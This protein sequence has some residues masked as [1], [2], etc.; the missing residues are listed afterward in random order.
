M[1]PMCAVLDESTSAMSEMNEEHMYTTMK[2]LGITYLSI[3]HRSTLQKVNSEWN[4]AMGVLHIRKQYS[5]TSLIH[6]L[7]IQF[8]RFPQ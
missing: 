2:H 4:Y 3:G 1:P 7:D 6:T 8:P 5:E